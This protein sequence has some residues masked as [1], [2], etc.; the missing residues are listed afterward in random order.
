VNSAAALDDPAGREDNSGSGSGGESH[1]PGRL[2]RGG[3]RYSGSVS[4]SDHERL[5][6]HAAAATTGARL[7]L[8]G[9]LDGGF[10]RGRGRHGGRFDGRLGRGRGRRGRC[11]GV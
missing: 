9:R 5:D 8:G 4:G 7:G 11:C 2:K 1:R 10:G 3:R 6:W